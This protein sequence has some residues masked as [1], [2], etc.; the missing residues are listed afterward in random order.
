ML[1]SGH[2]FVWLAVPVFAGVTLLIVRN[3]KSR[4][5]VSQA[6]KG[7]ICKHRERAYAGLQFGIVQ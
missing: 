5:A 2:S 4:A 1:P 3:L 7:Q 6:R